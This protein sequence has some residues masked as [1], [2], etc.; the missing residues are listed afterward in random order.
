MINI[1]ICDDDK[2][3]ANIIYGSVENIFLMHGTEARMFTYSSARALVEGMKNHVFDLI[4]L[5]I[6]MPGTDGIALGR[7]LR[8]RG[9]S[10]DIIF[11]SGR[12]DRVFETFEVHPF[13]F[14][15]KNTFVKDISAVIEAYIDK[16]N[17]DKDVC[18]ILVNSKEGMMALSVAK[19]MYIEGDRK[20]QLVHM[21]NTERPV[22]ISRSMEKLEEELSPSG[23]V[24]IHKGY[25]VSCRYI[26]VI[27]QQDLTLTDGTVLPVSRRKAKE[28]R[29]AYM[30]F[31]RDRNS[32]KLR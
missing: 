3:S 26:R 18:S 27:G 21:E 30:E 9:M 32:P 17:E 28:I 15:R 31:V 20:D 4:L 6:E 10:G 2:T 5:D 29:G 1:A 24:R 12:E 16:Y 11:I 23:F 19:I 7:A 13:G 14:V 25:I 8:E 22:V